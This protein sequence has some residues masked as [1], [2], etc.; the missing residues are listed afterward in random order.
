MNLLQIPVPEV[1]S[2]GRENLIGALIAAGSLDIPEVC[3]YF[4]NKLFRGNRTIKMDNSGLDAFTSPNMAP[5]ALMD[6]SI[7]GTVFY[8][9]SKCF[10]FSQLRIDFPKQHNCA[11]H[12]PRYN[13]P[14]CWSS[15]HLP[16]HS[17]RISSGSVAATYSRSCARDLWL[18]K[19]SRQT[20]RYYR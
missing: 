19:H 5:L 7:K 8:W 16:F 9:K 4:N 14:E 2:D 15:T 13:V 20:N 10:V 6:I 1:R 11:I 12:R 17:D 18:R 3:V